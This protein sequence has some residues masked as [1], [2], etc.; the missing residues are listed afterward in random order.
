MGLGAASVILLAT[1]APRISDRLLG[2]A[3][4][5][6]LLLAVHL[7]IGECAPLADTLGRLGVPLLF[8]RPWAATTLT[9]F[10]SRRWKLAFVEMNQRLFMRRLYRLSGKSGSRVAAFALSGVLHELA[11]SLP[12]ARAL[13]PEPAPRPY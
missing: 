6:A 3:G 4:I 8:D 11:L 9:E 7:G 10:W 12:G 1:F 13:T 2:L 5:A